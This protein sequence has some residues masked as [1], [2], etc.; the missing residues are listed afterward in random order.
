MT[1]IAKRFPQNPLL[2]PKH[3]KPTS[4]GLHIACLLNPGVFKFD[5][6]I[7]LLVRVAERPEQSEVHVSFPIL[8]ATGETQIMEIALDDADLI[9]T[10]ARVV[11]Y[12]GIDYLT[13]LSHLRLLCSDDGIHFY[14]PDGYPKLFGNGPLQ[15]FGIE[16]CR[17][18]FLEGT[19][20]LTFTAVSGSGVGVGMRTTVDWKVFQSH[21]IILPPHNKDVAI[22]EEKINGLY[23]A[24][25]RPSSVDIGG[26]YI[27]LS[28]SPDGIH[29]GNHKCIVKTREGMWDSGRVGGGAAPIKTEKGWLE[30]Y[31]GAT[32]EHRYCLGAV[33]LD[34]DDPSIVLART[35]DPIMEPTAP[36]EV[37]GFF[38]HVV[39]TNGHVLDGDTLTIYYGAAD[40][41][42]CGATFS[43]KEI[44][45]ALDV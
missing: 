30:I 9:A 7:W 35:A 24:L 45:A 2:S 23:Y 42:V 29:W 40:E 20:Y 1:D 39:F 36:Y 32:K 33:L 34:L 43:I 41:H 44:L 8:T 31:H 17:V 22:F 5:G 16:D 37:T 26:N 4:E 14:E 10:D 12:K 25:H 13:T 3:L 18:T 38:G 15:T 19:Y 27:W 11:R 28:Q 6:K 21:G